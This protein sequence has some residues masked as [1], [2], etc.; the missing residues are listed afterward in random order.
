MI[1]AKKANLWMRWRRKNWW[2]NVC[3]DLD[4]AMAAFGNVKDDDD[5]DDSAVVLHSVR[6]SHS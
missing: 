5:D 4:A 1:C 2:G 6:S 3:L